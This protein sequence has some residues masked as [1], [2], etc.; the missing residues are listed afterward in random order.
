MTQRC[1]CLVLL[2]LAILRVVSDNRAS[3]APPSTSSSAAPPRCSSKF[4]RTSG[5]VVALERTSREGGER[6]N[7]GEGGDFLLDFGKYKGL[8]LRN[9]P[10]LYLKWLR[11]AVTDKPVCHAAVNSFCSELERAGPMKDS[12]QSLPH[13]VSAAQ[14]R[15]QSQPGSRG[16]ETERKSV[17]KGVEPNETGGDAPHR[18]QCLT[19]EYWY[20]V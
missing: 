19:S 10:L 13:H 1:L 3:A 16:D 15:A 14:Q 5:T 9:V 7:F 8:T 6:S 12:C 20:P 11:T 18:P 4:A 17:R 2:V